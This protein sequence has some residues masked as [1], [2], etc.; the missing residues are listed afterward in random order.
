MTFAWANDLITKTSDAL[1]AWCN[2]L[3]T[4]IVTVSFWLA[5]LA[6]AVGLISRAVDDWTR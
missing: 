3:S 1:I 5:G 4:W 2:Y 6:I